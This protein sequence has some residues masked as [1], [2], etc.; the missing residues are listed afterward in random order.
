MT[1]VLR[2]ISGHVAG[3]NLICNPSTELTLNGQAFNEGEAGSITRSSADAYHGEY[4]TLVEPNGTN[5]TEGISYYADANNTKI[6]VHEGSP[7]IFFFWVKAKTASDLKGLMCYIYFYDKDGSAVNPKISCSSHITLSNTTWQLQWCAGIAP[8]GAVSCVPRTEIYVSE[9]NAADY[10]IDAANLQQTPFVDKTE[11]DGDQPGCQWLGDIHESRSVLGNTTDYIDFIDGDAFALLDDGLELPPPEAI[12]TFGGDPLLSDKGKRLI[13]R[14]YDNREITITF[15]IESQSGVDLREQL[16]KLQRILDSAV[17]AAKSGIPHTVYL[18]WAAETI[19]EP[20]LFDVVDGEISY[21][22]TSTVFARNQTMLD[23]SVKLITKPYG[24][25]KFVIPLNNHIINSDFDV[26]YGVSGRDGEQYRTFGTDGDR[27]ERA[28]CTGLIPDV[29]SPGGFTVWAWVYLTTVSGVPFCIVKAGNDEADATPLN[30]GAYKLELTGVS[31]FPKFTIWEADG[32]LKEVTGVNSALVDG[33]TFIAGVLDARSGGHGDHFS[34]YVDQRVSESKD[35]ADVPSD[36]RLTTGKFTV[37]ALNTN[38]E[39]FNAGRIQNVGYINVPLTG[40]EIQHLFKA[41]PKALTEDKKSWFTN[42]HFWNINSDS[43][44][45]SWPDFSAS[46]VVDVGPKG[47]DLTVVGSPAAAVSQQLPNGWLIGSSLTAASGSGLFE[48]GDKDYQ[49][50]TGR[51]SFLVKDNSGDANTYIRQQITIPDHKKNAGQNRWWTVAVWARSVSA[52]VPSQQIYIDLDTSVGTD[53]NTWVATYD[54]ADGWALRLITFEITDGSINFDL[55]FRGRLA[56]GVEFLIDSVQCLEGTPYGVSLD[57]TYAY[58]VSRPLPQITSRFLSRNGKNLIGKVPNLCVR[59]I[60]GD[61]FAGCKLYLRNNDDVELG[62]IRVGLLHGG[63][64]GRVQNTLFASGM[65]ID[66][67]NTESEYNNYNH[68]PYTGDYGIKCVSIT[69]DTFENLCQHPVGSLIPEAQVI[70]GTFKILAGIGKD[71][72]ATAG[73]MYSIGRLDGPF[74]EGIPL[75]QSAL[76]VV[77]QASVYD[78]ITTDLGLFSWPPLADLELL[79]KRTFQGRLR[80]YD[81]TAGTKNY[82][83]SDATRL[84]LRG[85]IDII[86]QHFYVVYL[87]FVP[88]ENGYFMFTPTSGSTGRLRE[89]EILVINGINPEFSPV[90]ITSYSSLNVFEED[91]VDLDAAASLTYSGNTFLLSPTESNLFTIL[92]E[93][94]GSVEAQGERIAPGELSEDNL[95]AHIAYE[96][97]YLYV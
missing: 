71:G 26:E 58:E 9:V 27:L 53:D 77:A 66:E 78:I 45:A 81:S 43:W 94:T 10:Y 5:A 91:I 34:V 39:R 89:N 75:T 80:S 24:R 92:W 29:A 12:R 30:R 62:P 23:A 59:D 69:A 20:I 96:A 15:K 55:S 65:L 93:E 52:S 31:R 41:G 3:E 82:N 88:V 56:F 84:Q 32:T 2:L 21:N 61:Q 86:S 54:R 74:G 57:F 63:D 16:N 46:P 25:S 7:Y 14:R 1:T 49:P 17:A 95:E 47:L 68:G 37:G 13:D 48:H 83:P 50:R 64:I 33:W 42:R 36:I 11:I 79:R 76:K 35:G 51:Y 22:F 90:Y 85:L 19:P 4:S 60:P 18:E 6:K 67:D 44:G 8:D 38:T 28:N 97:R 70:K 73:T 40:I 72:T 87:E